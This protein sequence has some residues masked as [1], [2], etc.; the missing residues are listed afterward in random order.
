MAT[1]RRDEF[2]RVRASLIV[3]MRDAG[4]GFAAI[5][6]AVNVHGAQEAESIYVEQAQKASIKASARRKQKTLQPLKMIAYAESYWAAARSMMLLGR[7]LAVGKLPPNVPPPHETDPDPGVVG[8]VLEAFCLEV[9]L[10]CLIWLTSNRVVDGHDLMALFDEL[11]EHVQRSIAQEWATIL[12]PQDIIDE[13]RKAAIV[14]E[15]ALERRLDKRPEALRRELEIARR[16]FERM[17]YE[18][19][20]DGEYDPHGNIDEVIVAVRRV[21][22][23]KLPAPR[24]SVILVRHEPTLTFDPADQT[25]KARKA[26]AMAK[27]IRNGTAASGKYRPPI[28]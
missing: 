24:P 3:E 10:K 6:T 17:R 22:D 4:D 5:A 18:Y 12:P 7:D 11:L 23:K 13:V 8:P 25:A 19:E 26:A 14:K 16:R 9:L 21:I 1:P 20:R 2:E 27:K 15:S 28:R